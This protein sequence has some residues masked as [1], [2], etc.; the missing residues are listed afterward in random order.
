MIE[1]R[2]YNKPRKI[3]WKVVAGLG[4]DPIQMYDVVFD[5]LD[6]KQRQLEIPPDMLPQKAPVEPLEARGCV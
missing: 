1:K 5:Q 6:Y 4:P 3:K 2:F